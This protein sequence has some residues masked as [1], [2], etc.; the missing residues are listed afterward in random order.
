MP[1][2]YLTPQQHDTLQRIVFAEHYLKPGGPYEHTSE[3][4]R[5][6]QREGRYRETASRVV[7]IIIGDPP[8]QQ[9]AWLTE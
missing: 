1:Q 5:H 6:L 8:P 7:E 9:P 3:F 2:L 4:V